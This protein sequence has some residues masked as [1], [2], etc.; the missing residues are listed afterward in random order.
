[1]FISF[2]IRLVNVRLDLL[3]RRGQMYIFASTVSI[4]ITVQ[5]FAVVK[6]FN[7]INVVVT[8]LSKARKI[9]SERY[10]TKTWLHDTRC[11][12]NHFF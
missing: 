7:M 10:G 6:L 11:H 3:R 2:Q 1:M 9:F 4:I 8:Y 12:L 5:M